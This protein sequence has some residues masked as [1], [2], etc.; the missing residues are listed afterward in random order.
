MKKSKREKAARILSLKKKKIA[1]NKEKMSEITRSLFTETWRTYMDQ[2]SMA[3]MK[4]DHDLHSQSKDK[5]ES[6]PVKLSIV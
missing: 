4:L 6:K 1:G 3:A 5:A 2:V